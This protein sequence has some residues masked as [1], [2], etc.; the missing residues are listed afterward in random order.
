M[1]VQIGVQ[2][3]TECT[4]SMGYHHLLALNAKAYTI[5]LPAQRTEL[6]LPI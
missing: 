4:T 5:D 3:L 1:G 2:G 6:L